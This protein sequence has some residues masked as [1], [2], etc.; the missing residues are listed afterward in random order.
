MWKFFNQLI[1]KLVTTTYV[2]KRFCFWNKMLYNW[3]INKDTHD[4]C[5]WDV[6]LE[7]FGV[8]TY[9]LNK[10]NNNPYIQLVAIR[11]QPSANTKNAHSIFFFFFFWTENIGAELT[12]A[13]KAHFRAQYFLQQT[14]NLHKCMHISLSNYIY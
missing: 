8:W 3:L 2:Y 9:A 14:R 10:M 5:V 13:F 11:H 1:C 12:M 6:L 4:F 7:Q